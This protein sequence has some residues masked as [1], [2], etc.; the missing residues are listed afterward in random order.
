ML[1]T[2]QPERMVL[3][4]DKVCRELNV[5]KENCDVVM[6]IDNMQRN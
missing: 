2:N 1:S 6:T 4:C 5:F 3:F